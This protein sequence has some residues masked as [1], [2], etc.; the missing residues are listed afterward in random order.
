M[1]AHRAKMSKYFTMILRR[2]E[3]SPLLVISQATLTMTTAT[4]SEERERGFIAPEHRCLIHV[5]HTPMRERVRA[6]RGGHGVD[7]VREAFSR[8]VCRMEHFHIG[9]PECYVRGIFCYR[10]AMGGM[11]PGTDR[12]GLTMI[13]WRG[14]AGRYRRSHRSSYVGVHDN[15]MELGEETRGVQRAP[16]MYIQIGLH[17]YFAV[18]DGTRQFPGGV[19]PRQASSGRGFMRKSRAS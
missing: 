16:S 19:P 8:G 15:K 7:T 18:V 6:A 1:G 17:P 4:G 14:E 13:G 12:A 2:H 5:V 10:R 9:I 11:E 3:C